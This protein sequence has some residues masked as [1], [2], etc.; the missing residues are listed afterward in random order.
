MS[1]NNTWEN[2]IA[3]ANPMYNKANTAILFGAL[4]G[5]KNTGN[6]FRNKLTFNSVPGQPS[7]KINLPEDTAPISI[8]VRDGNL[9]GVD[10][11][12]VNPGMHNFRLRPASPAKNMG[13]TAKGIGSVTASG[14]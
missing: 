10:P 14:S 7:V 3:V 8:S 4:N 12:F 11:Q 6:V 9:L 5:Y 1:S 13:I 2:N